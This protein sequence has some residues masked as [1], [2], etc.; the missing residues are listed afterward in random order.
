MLTA[1]RF[2]LMLPWLTVVRQ[3]PLHAAGLSALLDRT[4]MP[5]RDKTTCSGTRHLYVFGDQ[6]VLGYMPRSIAPFIW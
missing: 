3:G 2:G 5:V 4:A 1:L 6:W